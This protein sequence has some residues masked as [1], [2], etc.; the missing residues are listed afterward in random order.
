[1]TRRSRSLP[2]ASQ[3]VESAMAL[4]CTIPPAGRGE[5]RTTVQAVVAQ[6]TSAREVDN[7]V[8]LAFAHS[9]ETARLLLD[10][11]LAERVCCAQFVYS[12]A[13]RPMQEQ[14]E[15]TVEATGAQ[16]RPLK[17]LYLGLANEARR[18]DSRAKQ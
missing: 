9:D 1:M 10:L 17:D 16:I 2:Q 5:R 15:L 14:I 11:V 6:A 12:I 4:V 3:D 13:F 18:D 8:T 7:G